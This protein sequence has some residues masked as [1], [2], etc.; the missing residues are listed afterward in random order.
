MYL[1]IL[2]AY[3]NE[4]I[5]YANPEKMMRYLLGTYDFYK[6]IKENGD[7]SLQSFNMSGSL[8]WG[9]KIPLPD[10]VVDFSMKPGSKTTAFLNFNRGWQVSFRIHSAS[11]KVE[12]SLKFDV[13]LEGSP[14]QLSRHEIPYG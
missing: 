11:S 9:R 2:N 1:P 10:R 14:Q 5:R 4:V 13:R 6:V 3:I 12:P 8:K 7:I